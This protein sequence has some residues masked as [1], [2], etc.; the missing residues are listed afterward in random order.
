MG[1]DELMEHVHAA[2]LPVLEVRELGA[3][4]DLE[5]VVI[6]PPE[7]VALGRRLGV[8]LLYIER[9][10]FSADEAERISEEL[11]IAADLVST[12]AARL[13]GSS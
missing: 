6:M 3:R 2:A 11:R 12:S 10:V 13:P 1:P 4:V 8:A 5:P 7:F 9:L